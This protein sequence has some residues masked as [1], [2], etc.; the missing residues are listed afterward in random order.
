MIKKLKE[1]FERAEG[2]PE[3]VQNEAVEA[4]LSIEQG[5]IGEYELTA[6]DR[7]ALERSAE[8]V[9]VGR[10]ATDAEVAEL[11]ARGRRV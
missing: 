4:L 2:W 5:H 1:L 7:A 6:E 10:F 3:Q 11:F 8:D 9:R